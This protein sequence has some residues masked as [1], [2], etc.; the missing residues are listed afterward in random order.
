MKRPTPGEGQEEKETVAGTFGRAARAHDQSG[1]R[2]HALLG[3]RLARLAD[4][5]PGQA[6]L[7]VGA[8]RGASALPAAELAGPRG[9]VVAVDL[10]GPM[11]AELKRDAE[12]RGLHNLEVLVMDA[13]DLAFSDCAFDRVLAGFCLFFFPRPAQALAEMRRV[14]KPGGRLA[15]STWDMADTGWRWLDDLFASYLPGSAGGRPPAAG[16]DG[17]AGSAG[18]MRT[19]LTRAGFESVDVVGDAEELVYATEDDWWASLRTGGKR[20]SLERIE[21]EL[22]AAGLARLEAEARERLRAENPP[23]RDGIHR[24]VP[25]LFSRARRPRQQGAG[26]PS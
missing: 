12:A 16:L 24:V 2:L 23:G 20:G 1:P 25:L 8:G 11:V 15:L 19:I 21:A 17:V 7:D 3:E 9:R 13:E 5:R 14:L 22:G 4:I 18:G 6:V 26:H 10:A